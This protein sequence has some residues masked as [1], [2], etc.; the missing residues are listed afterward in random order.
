MCVFR[1]SSPNDVQYD[2]R[3][4]GFDDEC[5]IS[6]AL[7]GGGGTAGN[8]FGVHGDEVV[9]DDG[10]HGERA[11][12]VGEGVEGVMGDHGDDKL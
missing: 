6:L 7:N 9:Y 1:W 3:T 5:S 10:A 8:V 11:E 12:S 2:E 4:F